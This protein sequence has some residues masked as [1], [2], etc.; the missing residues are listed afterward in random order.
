MCIFVLGSVW[1]YSFY[2]RRWIYKCEVNFGIGRHSLAKN[3][4]FSPNPIISSFFIQHFEYTLYSLQ[5]NVLITNKAGSLW[6][7][8][9][10]IT[11][12]SFK[13]EPMHWLPRA[14]NYMLFQPNQLGTVFSFVW[15]FLKFVTLTGIF[16]QK[17]IK[18]LLLYL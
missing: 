9:Q 10:T 2:I 4:S 6:I 17:K 8:S 3:N 15:D 14:P 16:H 13:R 18:E 7:S 5:Y 1:V 12:F 11:N